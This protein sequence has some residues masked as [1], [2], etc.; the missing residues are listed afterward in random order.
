MYFFLSGE[1]VTDLG[2]GRSNTGVCEDS[3]FIVGPMT[4]V[5][6][7]V[8]EK[9]QNYSM[10]G[11]CVYVTEQ[12]I[13]EC[14]KGLKISGKAMR[15]PGVRR[16]KE[17]RYF[18]NNARALSKLAK[19]KER[20][21]S[22][23]V[24]AVLFRDADG[25]AS[26]GRGDWRDKRQSMLDGFD[27]EEF[28]RGVPMIPKPKSEAWL[29]C[30]MKSNPYQGCEKLEER[31]GNDHS[32]KSL[33]KELEAILKARA[34]RKLLCEKVRNGA[35]EIGKIRMPSFTAFRKRLESVI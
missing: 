1:G 24:V 12:C 18:F 33:K 28:S 17:T 26:A 23:K 13:A 5:V 21:L 11:C 3:D 25:A 15:L 34:T 7:K 8:V 14:A 19:E 30:A 32:P 6:E 2:A 31:S 35:F 20:E 9:S 27:E 4:V 10:L 22:D 16:P 29:I